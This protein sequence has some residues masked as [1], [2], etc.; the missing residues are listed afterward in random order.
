[1]SGYVEQF[2]IHQPFTTVHE[3]LQF[4]AHL[5][6]TSDTPSDT[7]EQFITEVM[8]LVELD[9]LA[10]ALVGSSTAICRLP[11]MYTS[12]LNCAF[13]LFPLSLWS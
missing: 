12:M 13:Y 4:S 2:D 5:R 1:M 3:A 9:S 8:A 7:V 10:D 6:F 11:M